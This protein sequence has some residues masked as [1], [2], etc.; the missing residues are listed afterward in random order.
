MLLDI[1]IAIKLTGG[2]SLFL[3]FSKAVVSV[4]SMIFLLAGLQ[5]LLMGMVDDGIVRKMDGRNQIKLKKY[6]I[7]HPSK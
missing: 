6:L 1:L 2:H 4:T 5:I 7:V 3:L